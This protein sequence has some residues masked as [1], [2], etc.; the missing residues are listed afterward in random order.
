M[1]IK[2]C[3]QPLEKYPEMSTLAFVCRM[4]IHCPAL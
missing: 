4:N 1:T 2:S 3:N